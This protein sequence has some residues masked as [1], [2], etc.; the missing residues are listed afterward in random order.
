MFKK[1]YAFAAGS[2]MCETVNACRQVDVIK[3]SNA[4]LI[5][6]YLSHHD[7]VTMRFGVG[8]L[9]AYQYSNIFHKNEDIFVPEGKISFPCFATEPFYLYMLEHDEYGDDLERQVSVGCADLQEGVNEVQI[10]L[11]EHTKELSNTFDAEKEAGLTHF[12]FYDNALIEQVAYSIT[13]KVGGECTKDTPLVD[14][15]IEGLPG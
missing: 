4:N 10:S 15:S 7:E 6:D 3:F 1:L 9:L 14:D 12:H 11:D 2:F 13:L 8:E 5:T